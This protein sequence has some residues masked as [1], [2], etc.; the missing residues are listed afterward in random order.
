LRS[1]NEYLPVRPVLDGEPVALDDDGEPDFPQLCA[2]VLM[3]R[4]T[5]PLTFMAFDVLSVD[6]RN[7]MGLQ[8][9]ERR[10][11]LEDLN[12]N[13]RFWRTPEAFDDG[14]A[15]WEAVCGHQ[16]EGVV[17]K[18]RSGGYVPG[19][20]TWIKAKNHDYWRWELER[21]GAFKARR[22]APQFV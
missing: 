15:L 10:A 22:R 9:D 17:A 3:R 12:L 19:E 16:L 20:R 2:C 4:T 8:Y 13:D 5:A 14:A 7:V 11:I 18:R 1:G 21:E 6:G